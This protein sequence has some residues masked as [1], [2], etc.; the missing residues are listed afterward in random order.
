MG[1]DGDKPIASA[2]CDRD[3]RQRAVLLQPIDRGARCHRRDARP[4]PGDL[5]G[6][7]LGV[8]AG[9]EADDLQTIRVRVDDGERALTDRA[10][11]SEDRY[12]FHQG[13][14]LSTTED[15]EDTEE[16]TCAFMF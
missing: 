14:K 4:I 10:G 11:G 13:H 9:R 6:E 12:S 7:E 3:A 1:G 15:T 2:A 5:C 16:E 8:L